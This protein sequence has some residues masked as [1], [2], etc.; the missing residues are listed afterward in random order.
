ME[1]AED[2]TETIPFYAPAP[3]ESSWAEPDRL[4]AFTN[5]DHEYHRGNAL[6]STGCGGGEGAGVC[7]VAVGS[8]LGYRLLEL[9]ATWQPVPGA[10][11]KGVV[12]AVSD[13]DLGLGPGSVLTLQE[14]E[15]AASVTEMQFDG[16]EQVSFQW[17]NPDFHFRIL[18][19][20]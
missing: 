18:I 1:Q 14:E 12:T 10:V 3:K 16:G 9:S 8:V 19:S 17:K 7:L 20:N 11:R 13:Q 4:V 6:D 2:L 5:L 15:G